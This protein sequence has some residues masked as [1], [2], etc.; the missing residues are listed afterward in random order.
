MVVH[1]KD[2]RFAEMWIETLWEKVENGLIS[3]PMMR[4]FRILILRHWVTFSLLSVD[5][6]LVIMISLFCLKKKLKN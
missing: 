6:Q 3:Q 4:N 1:L 2:Q 5:W